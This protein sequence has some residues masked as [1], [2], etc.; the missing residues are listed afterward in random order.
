MY[1]CRQALSQ[2]RPLQTSQTSQVYL[3]SLC[4]TVRFTG[5]INT[6]NWTFGKVATR[7]RRNNTMKKR[8]IDETTLP[9]LTVSIWCIKSVSSLA[10]NSSVLQ[11]QQYTE[12][13]RV[14]PNDR[15]SH[16]RKTI[17]CLQSNAVR[18]ALYRVYIDKTKQPLNRR[19]AQLLRTRLRSFLTP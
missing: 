18:A 6:T 17:W 14:H 1:I 19:M 4:V 7:S 2:M 10:Y 11:P 15:T 9:T 8:R 5:H 16:T 3:I 12:Q 13:K